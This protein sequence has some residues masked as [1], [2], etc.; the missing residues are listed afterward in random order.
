MQKIEQETFSVAQTTLNELAST[1]VAVLSILDGSIDGE[2][3]VDSLTNP[4]VAV[5]ANGDAYY[6][7]GDPL[8]QS[9]TLEQVRCILPDWA[10]LFV[11]DRWVPYLSEA[12]GN[13]HALPHPRIRMGNATG[14]TLPAP[15]QP[16]EGF[17]V[18]KIDQALFDQ[19]PGNLDTLEDCVE[20]WTS[21]EAFFRSA[22]GY[23]VLHD[24]QIVSHCVTD[25]VTGNRCEIGVGTEPGFRRLGLGRV[26]S[27]M[28]AAECIRRSIDA[29]EWH[30]HSSNRGSLSI[31]KS[32][33]FAELDRHTAYSLRLPAE[34]VGDL[35]PEHCRE[36]AAYFER[37][38]EDINWSRFFAAGAR[39]QA[40]DRD[41]AIENVRLLIESDW[42]GEAEWLERFWALST[43]LGDP[44]LQALIEHKR[45]LEV[46]D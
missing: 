23:C 35:S 39:A 14:A 28:T 44:E 20:G 24:G 40:G 9:H 41:G 12:W 32:I 25:S 27:S 29:I 26:V 5:A 19:E 30:C 36:L 6:L 16:P 31:G 8:A 13:P 4:Q 21:R 10:Y 42:E 17:E 3:W 18:V 43:L 1:H 33:G 2:V 34:N 22:V 15:S 38:S 45:S 46:A 11:E 37:A 7:A